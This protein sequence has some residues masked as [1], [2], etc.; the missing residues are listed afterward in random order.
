MIGPVFREGRIDRAGIWWVVAVLAVLALLDPSAAVGADEA[1]FVERDGVLYV[2]NVPPAGFWAGWAGSA[3]PHYGPL[4]DEMAERY[5]VPATLVAAVIRAESNF[6]PRAISPKGARGLM[7]LM[8]A[9]AARLG[10]RDVF[11]PRENV[12]GGV[13]Y[14]RDLI[15]QYAGDVRLA[16]AAYNAGPEPVT[17]LRAVPPYPETQSYVARVMRLFESPQLVMAERVEA[18][19][20][21]E[22]AQARQTS[23][24]RSGLQRAARYVAP[25]GTIVYTNVPIESL[26]LTTRDRLAKPQTSGQAPVLVGGE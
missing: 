6:D 19:Q 21:R 17:R 4:I 7:Q 22:R 26:P 12:Q 23:A 10:V 3:N 20:P 2:F 5:Q 25:D 9:T 13:R 14:L 11:D 8:P 16:V 18:R 24:V 1:S 15:T